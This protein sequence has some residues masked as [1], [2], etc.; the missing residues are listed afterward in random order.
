M[1][2]SFNPVEVADGKKMFIFLVSSA[3]LS[4]RPI[5]LQLLQKIT[6]FFVSDIAVSFTLLQF[7]VL[8]KSFFLIVFKGELTTTYQVDLK[9]FIMI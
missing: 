3:T 8:K 2:E 9:S 7:C 1:V 4:H 5:K 6:S